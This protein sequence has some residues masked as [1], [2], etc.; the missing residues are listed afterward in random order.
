MI[1]PLDIDSKGAARFLNRESGLY[2]KAMASL[3]EDH[4][5]VEEFKGKSLRRTISILETTFQLSGATD[6]QHEIKSFQIDEALLKAALHLK[7][8]SAQ[9]N[10]VVHSVGILLS[11]PHI[12]EPEEK[13]QYLS[14]AA[15]NTGRP[16]DL[17][18]NQR[19]AEFKFIDWKGGSESIRQNS[20]FKDFYDLVEYDTP[21]NRFLYVVG[22]QHP[23]KFFNGGRACKSVMS[24]KRKLWEQYSER[25]PQFTRVR[26]FYEHKK[27]VVNIVDLS[28]IVPA[29][30]S[31]RDLLE[32]AI[33]Q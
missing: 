15:G 23:M 26:A 12:L 25:Y 6:C 7:L 16:F 22:L 4:R 31:T 2:C 8:A 5:R 21:K 10:E 20:L 9:I 33:D 18:T 28:T 30:A 3:D 13:V 17:E 32:K 29:F 1:L 14:L 27:S 24:G 19:I 11:L